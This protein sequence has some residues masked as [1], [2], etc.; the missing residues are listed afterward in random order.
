MLHLVSYQSYQ[1]SPQVGVLHLVSY[2]SYQESPKSGVLHLV[3]YQSY[4]ESPKSGC[5]SLI[6]S[7]PSRGAELSVLSGVPTFRVGG[8]PPSATSSELSVLSG[9]PQVR[10]AT[11]IPQVGVSVNYQ[12]YQESPKSGCYI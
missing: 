11:S 8:S 1:E 2:Q 6:R 4:Q 10:G 5:C 12:S 7:P 9:V 3:S